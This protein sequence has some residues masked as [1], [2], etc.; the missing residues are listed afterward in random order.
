MYRTHIAL[1][2]ER[3]A[4]LRSIHSSLTALHPFQKTLPLHGGSFNLPFSPL[5]HIQQ[6]QSHSLVMHPSSTSHSSILCP[7]IH[8]P[9]ASPF[10]SPTGPPFSHP[11]TLLSIIASSYPS[12][13]AFISSSFPSPAHATFHMFATLP[14]T[15]PSIHPHP[16]ILLHL[17]THPS[18][19]L[20]ILLSIIQSCV[21][22]PSRC[23]DPSLSA[24]ILLPLHVTLIR[25]FHTD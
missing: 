10:L 12:L 9:C 14:F 24:L 7:L 17:S 20:F 13:S 2:S 4:R 16:V 11:S 8:S 21:L 23:L 6:G 19:Q 1:A 18:S 22:P 5:I 15:C 25:K 3:R